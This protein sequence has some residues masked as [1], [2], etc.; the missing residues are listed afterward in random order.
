MVFLLRDSRTVSGFPVHL[1]EKA[2]VSPKM[3]LH[4]WRGPTVRSSI[5]SEFLFRRRSSGVV[6]RVSNLLD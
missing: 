6:S 5:A 1:N 4:Y 3:S 2:F